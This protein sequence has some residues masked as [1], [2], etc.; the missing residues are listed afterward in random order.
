MKKILLMSSLLFSTSVF[1]ICDGDLT[2]TE[3]NICSAKEYKDA[4]KVL[5]QTYNS[6]LSKLNAKEKKQFKAV[7]LNWI[8]YKE[9]DCKY[10]AS[11]YE[12]GSIQPLVINSCLTDKTKIRTE[13]LKM[14]LEEVS[15]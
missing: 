6:Y 7:Q 9:S 1:A 4:D 5:N 11:G 8:K 10:L 14:Y 3:L 2:Q 15:R 13:E 12:G